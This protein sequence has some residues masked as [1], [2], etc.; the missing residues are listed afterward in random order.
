MRRFVA[1]VTAALLAWTILP[2]SAQAQDDDDV[3]FLTG[4]LQESLS[5]AGR[6]VRITG[7]RGAL[8]SRATIEEMTIADD[9]GV[10]LVLRGAAMQWNRTALLARRIEIAELTAQEMEILRPPVPDE[11][12]RLQPEARDAPAQPFALPDLPVSVELRELAI[13][14]IVLGEAILGEEIVL[15]AEGAVSLAD[16]DGQAQLD[17]LRVDGTEGG[18]EGGAEGQ[19]RLRGAF[20]NETRQLSLDLDV[21]EGPDGIAARLLNLPDRPATALRITGD[22]PLDDFAAEISV[23]TDGV[24]RIGGAVRIAAPVEDAPQTLDIDIAGDLRPLLDAEFHGFFGPDS[25][26]RAQARRTPDGRVTLDELLVATELL[27]LEGRATVAGDGVP[28]MID[29][30]GRLRPRDDAPV[31]LPLPGPRTTVRNAEL[32]LAFDA[33]QSEDWELDFDLRELVRPGLE[34]GRIVA[35]GIGRIT[36]AEGGG[37]EVID[38][39]LDFRAEGI[40]PEDPNLARAIGDRVDGNVGAIWRA[41]APLSVPGLVI[42]G[43]DYWLQGE[44]AF[45]DGSVSLDVDAELEALE[46]FS[47]LAGRALSGALAGRLRGEVVPLTGGFDL[48]TELTGQDV[49]LDIDEID[50]LLSGRSEIRLSARRGTDGIVIRQLVAQARTLS[51][52]VSGRL[53]S[54][55]LD[56]DGDLRFTDLSVLGPQY[57]GDLD[58]TVALRTRNGAEHLDMRATGR[59]L[60][61]GQAELDRALRGQT[62][63]DV[64]LLR[65][66]E[67]IELERMTL[68]NPALSARLDGRIAPGASEIDAVF[69]LPALSNI[70]PGLAGAIDGTA[71][72]RE[73]GTQRRVALDVTANGLRAGQEQAD[74]L[75]AGT[76]RLRAVGTEDGGEV[77][78]QSAELSNPQLSARATGTAAAPRRLQI[79]ARL[80]DLARVVPDFSG[81]A[82]LRGSVEQGAEAITL[83]LAGTGP[84]GITARTSG[85][86]RTTDLTANLRV[87]G[88]ADLALITPVIT[89]GSIQG[90]VQFDLGLNGPLALRS[91]TGTATVAGAT[92]VQPVVNLR[93]SDIAARV[94][95]GAGQARI[96]LRGSGARGGRFSVGGSVQLEG[97]QAVDLAL[98]L[99]GLVVSDPQL[100]E[101]GVSGTA[102]FTGALAGER[103]V[104]GDLTIDGA[105]IRIPSTG[106]GGPGYVPPGIVHR[107]ESAASQLTRERAGL[108]RDDAARAEAR[109]I[110]LDL[111]LDAPNRVFIRGRGLDAELGGSLRLTG[112]TRDVIQIGEFGLIRG[113]LDLLGNRFTLTEGYASLQGEFTPFVR[114]VATTDSGGVSTSIALEG[115]ASAP[116]ITFSS[117]PELPEEEVVSRLIFDREL[118]SL[119]AFQAAQLAS[120]LAT[121]SGRGGNGLME[122]LRS[123]VGLDDLDITTDEDGN[124]AVRAGRYVTENVYTDVV[125]DPQGRSE[126]TINLDVSP[127]LT[128]RG[129][130]DEQGRAGVGVFFERDY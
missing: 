42:E 101:A 5:A 6:D 61:V 18:A 64:A 22:A 63:L 72:L 44:A 68:E 109:P 105:E 58:A 89:P 92:F 20:T 35:S 96:D 95:L 74:A 9:E 41:G 104:S 84:G 90:P 17:I 14:R 52:D 81:P 123:S 3:G 124:A 100:F 31:V 71:E 75:L 108:M 94:E 60:A 51:A 113:R 112:T 57:G 76:T 67:V 21:S 48:E 29:L 32:R 50:S 120:A 79:E 27:R 25:R 103:L 1:I 26:L 83:D 4:L 19:V 33:M 126:V 125:L 129:R 49:T 2:A 128:V 106:L 11:A 107:N 77:V 115:E 80:A 40:A 38:A 119:S 45:D 59:G 15:S 54:D 36:P 23:A 130:V 13:A 56:L 10:W 122:R 97:A 111:T 47:G 8:R 86:I 98:R 24:Q 93:L 82:E 88:A 70:R 116:Q 91:L 73:V 34:V 65:R 117:V 53:R 7:F 39:M 110:R 127:Q 87:T 99:D 102:A 85:S 16:G 62:E 30:S 118:A 28:E 121:L 114:L 46:R 78:L 43:A 12:A 66:G 69:A 37:A 55:D